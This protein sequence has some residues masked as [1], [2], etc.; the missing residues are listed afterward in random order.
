MK[1]FLFLFLD[2]ETSVCNTS[3][4]VNAAADVLKFMDASIDPCNDFYDFACG[5]FLA[6]TVL[7]DEK[8]SVDTFSIAR[9]T[10][11]SQILK[12]IDSPIVENDLRYI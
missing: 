12:L 6:D 2:K 3:G 10:M 8:V 4:C 1:L 11:Q 5:K 9:D 7:S